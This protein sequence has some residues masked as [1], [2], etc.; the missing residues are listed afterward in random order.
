MSTTR[1]VGGLPLDPNYHSIQAGTTISGVFAVDI[2]SSTYTAI[3]LPTGVNCKSLILKT[4][5]G[6]NWLLATSASPTAYM[7]VTGP[8]SLSLVAF[9]GATICYAKGTVSDTLEVLAIN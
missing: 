4:R 6:G 2:N 7:T 5:A 9:A 1:A 3:P 8:L